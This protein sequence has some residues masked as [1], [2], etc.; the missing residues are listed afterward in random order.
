MI[1]YI[2]NSA[3]F[4]SYYLIVIIFGVFI[5]LCLILTIYFVCQELK[6]DA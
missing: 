5:L 6:K 1:K 3:Y 4:S 2:F